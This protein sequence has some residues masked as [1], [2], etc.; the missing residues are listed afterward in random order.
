[1]CD[2][3]RLALTYRWLESSTH[4][5][6]RG[7]RDHVIWLTG[8]RGACGLGRLAGRPIF[9]THWGLLG[10]FESVRKIAARGS[11][12]SPV[13][14]ARNATAIEGTSL[15][16]FTA[17]LSS[18]TWCHAPHK[19]V[20]VPPYIAMPERSGEKEQRAPLWQARSN[21]LIHAGGVCGWRDGCGGDASKLGGT[22]GYSM[23]MR[24]RIFHMWGGQPGMSARISVYNH[25]AR[26]GFLKLMRSSQWCLATA[27]DGWG[28]RL[29]EAVLAG[30][31]PLIAQPAVLQPFEDVLPYEYFSARLD[32]EDVATLPTWLADHEQEAALL[33][34]RLHLV[35]GAFQWGRTGLAYNLTLLSLCH[36]AVELGLQLKAGPQANCSPLATR[37]NRELF[38]TSAGAPHSAPGPIRIRPTWYAPALDDAIHEAIA[39]RRRGV[40]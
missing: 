33:R 18:A 12:G 28:T 22:N 19:D 39:L 27:G 14:E 4:W 26:G 11:A 31:V 25:S 3:A 7:G 24:Q 32:A 29:A 17:Q 8:D 1:M 40:A 6:R 35:R 9:V 15:P 34:Q 20:V 37:I 36:R 38:G 5:R 21:R 16:R 23:G 10:A 30:C 2:A 13:L